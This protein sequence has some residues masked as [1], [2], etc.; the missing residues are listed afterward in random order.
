MS[1][2]EL[3]LTFGLG[4]QV[5]ADRVEIDWPSGQHE[6]LTSVNADQTITVQEGA[7]IKG[8]RKYSARR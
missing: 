4:E 5:K 8:L 3:V 6:L 1:Q 2:S 7:G